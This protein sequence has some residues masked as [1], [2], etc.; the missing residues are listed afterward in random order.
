MRAKYKELK[1]RFEVAEIH[2]SKGLSRLLSLM[3]LRKKLQCGENVEK[4]ATD[5]GPVDARFSHLDFID[6]GLEDREASLIVGALAEN[7]EIVEVV[8]KENRLSAYGMC[9]LA[10]RPT[11]SQNIKLSRGLTLIQVY[12]RAYLYVILCIEPAVG[13]YI[14]LL[15]TPTRTSMRSDTSIHQSKHLR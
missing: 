2:K 8:L 7:P 10:Y 15:R 6:M 3:E 4:D 11:S 9:M 14:Q 13:I 12:M 5:G 1:R